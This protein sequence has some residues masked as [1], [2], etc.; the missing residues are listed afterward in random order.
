[1]RMPSSA[2]FQDLLDYTG[3]Q[4]Q[5]WQAW[6]QDT[7]P[8]ALAVSTGP[9]GD[10]RLPTIGAL[11]RHIFSAELRYVERVLGSPVS[12]TANV[13]TS[14][15]QALFELGQ[16]G[17]AQFVTLGDT[18][19]PPA[20]DTPVEFPL[21]GTTVHLTPRKVALHILT[22]EIRHWAQVGTI[23]RLDG[24]KVPSQD[25]LL[26]PVQGAPVRL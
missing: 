2:F 23:L 15:I 10:G 9:H 4:R 12:E 6:L 13:P 7:G 17:R 14:D 21:L 3:W 24:R 5:S 22:H 19:P 18:L 1:M 25:V 11:I 26:S 20:W 8:A 16:R